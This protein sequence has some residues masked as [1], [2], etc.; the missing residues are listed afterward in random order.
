M[1]AP[2]RMTLHITTFLQ[3]KFL[4]RP[5]REKSSALRNPAFAQWV[6]NTFRPIPGCAPQRSCT[7]FPSVAK[8]QGAPTAFLTLVMLS[9]ASFAAAPAT[10][11]YVYDDLNRLTGVA[12]NEGVP[13][14]LYRYDEISNIQWIGTENSPD[15][16][17]D[18]IPNFVDPDDDDDGIPDVAEIEAGLNSLLAADAAGDFDGDG[19]NNIDE[20]VLGSDINHFH[21]DF[22]GDGDLD[23]GDIVILKRIIFEQ[24]A[25]TEEQGESGHGDVNI[26]GALDIGDL[27][28]LRRLYFSN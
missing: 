25:A 13:M 4:L 18:D 22:D 16:D 3:A 6:K 5:R 28:I 19:I 27:V 24:V 2:E 9:V 7:D 20:Y 15:T 8:R 12:R 10:I 21:G 23:L 11:D 14:V 26:N 17:G 1:E